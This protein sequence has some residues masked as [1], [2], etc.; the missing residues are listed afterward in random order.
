MIILH[1]K[2]CRMQ[3]KLYLEENLWHLEG[4]LMMRMITWGQEL[5]GKSPP[6]SQFCR[7]QKAAQKNKH[8]KF[9]IEKMGNSQ[10]GKKK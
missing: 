1:I 5:Y 6:S 9:K 8:V 3:Y 10:I 2:T 7:E 4:I